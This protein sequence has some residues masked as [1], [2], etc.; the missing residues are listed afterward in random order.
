MNFP[1]RAA[2]IEFLTK[3]TLKT[4][5]LKSPSPKLKKL[6]LLLLS[7]LLPKTIAKTILKYYPKAI[8]PKVNML[9]VYNR[10]ILMIISLHRALKICRLGQIQQ[11]WVLK[12]PILTKKEDRNSHIRLEYISLLKTSNSRRRTWV[13]EAMN[14]QHH[15]K[16]LEQGC[17]HLAFLVTMLAQNI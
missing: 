16:W 2:K 17:L 12:M 15:P 6:L 4:I 9:R 3:F 5:Q 13:M 10:I 1:S 7:N 11:L 8:L 14:C